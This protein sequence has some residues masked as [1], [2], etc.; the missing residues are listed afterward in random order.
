[1][2]PSP[3]HGTTAF[4]VSHRTHAG[5]LDAHSLRKS[6]LSGAFQHPYQSTPK[7]LIPRGIH[8]ANKRALTNTRLNNNLIPSLENSDGSI[9]CNVTVI[10]NSTFR[11]PTIDHLE[12]I[13]ERQLLHPLKSSQVF[14]V[15]SNVCKYGHPQAFGF[16]PTN[17]PKVVSGLF[18]L[19]CP[20]L[21]QA[22]D[23][24][25]GEGGVRQ[26][27]DWLRSDDRDRGKEWKRVGYEKANE[28]Q[29]RIRAELAEDDRG[30]LV[31]RMGEFNAQRFMESGVA[32][33]PSS[34]TYNVK[35]IHAHVA[36]HLCRCPSSNSDANAMRETAEDGSEG[37]IIGKQALRTLEERGLPIMGND[38]CWQ[39]CTKRNQHNPT[40]WKYVPKKNR[41]RLRSTRLRRKERTTD[42]ES[43]E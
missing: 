12:T 36:D 26:M 27:S 9:N 29:K 24:W 19:S 33:I 28:M 25:E 31:S 30:K 17:G 10:A 1:M 20:L 35:C 43:G 11:L 7:Y 13:E 42:S 5:G 22:I 16:H 21:C 8:P 34:Q 39:Q 37:N 18:R 23:E 38:V 4:I 15:S 14:C 32:G 3:S 41:Q 40:D 6:T 2:A